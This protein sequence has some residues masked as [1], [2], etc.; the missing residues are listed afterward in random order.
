MVLKLMDSIGLAYD[1]VLIVPAYS[2]IAT[3]DEVSTEMRL[4][5]FTFKL[6]VVASPMDTICGS[7]MARRMAELGCLGILHRFMTIRENEYQYLQ[8]S[9]GGGIVGVSVGVKKDEYE[10]AEA[11]LAYNVPIVCVDVAHAHHELA[12]KMV[13]Y[14]SQKNVFVIAGTV[15]TKEGVE[16]LFSKGADA[17]HVGIGAG[18]VCTTRIVT[19]VGVPQLTAIMECSN[20]G[21]PIL[22]NGGIRNSGDVAKSIA[23]GASMVILGRMLAGTDEALNSNIYRG[24]ASFGDYQE[25]VSVPVAK[26]G[27]VSNVID[28]IG[29]GLRSSMSYVGARNIEQF[30][31]RATFIRVTHATYVEG[32]SR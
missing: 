17:I 10:R 23:A 12:G 32:L 19:G 28:A 8:A 26:Q 27:P 15:A 1:D 29:K 7:E 20:L 4:G 5:D 2:D 30:R 9:I 6:P 11:L 14:L 24:M 22:A 21:V 31:E 18:S 3:R 25:G 16:Y 13:E